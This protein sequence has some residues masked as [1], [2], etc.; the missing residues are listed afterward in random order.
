MAVGRSLVA[1]QKALVPNTD[2][3]TQLELFKFNR[4]VVTVDFEGGD[5]VTDADDCLA[6][7]LTSNSGFSPK[8]PG[9]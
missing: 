3:T 5:V 7:S 6:S 4:Q 9:D 2:C 1:A 8:P